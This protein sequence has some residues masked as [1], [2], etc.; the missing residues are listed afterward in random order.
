MAATSDI[1]RVR[2]YIS[3]GDLWQGRPLYQALLEEL[4]RE[5][6]TGATALRGMAG[7]G[8]GRFKQPIAGA[9]EQAAHPPVVIEWIDH[10]ARVSQVLPL[11]DELVPDA[12][13][14]VEP[15]TVYRAVLRSQGPFAGKLAGEIAQTKFAAGQPEMSL[16]TALA[17]WLASDQSAL[18][19]LDAERRLCG[20]LA[21]STLWRIGLRLP[22]AILR[23]LNSAQRQALLAVVGDRRLAEVMNSEVRSVTSGVAVSQALT[24][25]IEWNLDQISVVDH[26][27]RVVGVVS[28][29][30][31][32][33]AAI[34]Q[35]AT[36]EAG[37]VRDAEPPTPVR[38]VMQTSVSQIKADTPLVTGLIQ[39]LAGSQPYLV[40]IDDAGHVQGSLDLAGIFG[41]LAA[42]EQEQVLAAIQSPT[43]ESLAALPGADHAVAAFSTRPVPTIAPDLSVTDAIRFLLTHQLERA[44]VVD[45]QHHLLGLLAL[46]GL[47]RALVQES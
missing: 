41:R 36:P 15:V 45:E 22:L 8:P 13:I 38:L 42:G 29:R 1:Q 25:M 20:T 19:V 40:V 27:G 28:H 16:A 47:L 39:L 37:P 26:D 33:Q 23:Q 5:G 34:E 46:S 18:P 2:I 24:T 44:P 31:G 3:E 30:D 9:T 12:L 14:T 11:L 43:A 35:A 7:F 6:A 17:T 32:L 21:V 4:R 10:T